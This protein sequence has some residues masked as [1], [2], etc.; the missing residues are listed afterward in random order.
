MGKEYEEYSLVWQECG[1]NSEISKRFFVPGFEG[2]LPFL[3]SGQDVESLENKMP[4]ALNEKQLFFGIVLGMNDNAFSNDLL[5]MQDIEESKK[6][7]RY[8]LDVLVNGFSY[9]NPE[10]ALLDMAATIRVRNGG[11]LAEEALLSSVQLM[12]ESSKIKADLVVMMWYNFESEIKPMSELVQIIELV[13]QIN[14]NDIRADVRELVAYIGFAAMASDIKDYDVSEHLEAW[15]Y[16]Y[17]QNR[18]LKNKIKEALEAEWVY[19]KSMFFMK[20]SNCNSKLN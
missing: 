15:V 2:Y 19:A 8:L 9:N 6:T 17:V 5:S 10:Q 1:E 12:P 18:I 4:V 11:F 3:L 20:G 13:K 7:W 16:P 14:P